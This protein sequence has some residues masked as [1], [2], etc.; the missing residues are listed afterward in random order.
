MSGAKTT[1]LSEQTHRQAL[2]ITSASN[3][4]HAH[5]R[6]SRSQPSPSM[7]TRRSEQ[8]LLCRTSEFL[9]KLRGRIEPSSANH[10]AFEK[11]WMKIIPLDSRVD[12]ASLLAHYKRSLS[13]ITGENSMSHSSRELQKFSGIQT[14]FLKLSASVLKRRQPAR[15]LPLTLALPMDAILVPHHWHSA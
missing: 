2:V 14:S 11:K 4:K 6:D 12:A 10:C 15:I 9:K 5:K 7:P 8:P 13:K 1:P 3:Q